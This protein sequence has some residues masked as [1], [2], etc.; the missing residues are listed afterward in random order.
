MCRWNP[1][2]A[3]CPP[4][5]FVRQCNVTRLMTSRVSRQVSQDPGDF[6][7]PDKNSDEPA[8]RTLAPPAACVARLTCAASSRVGAKTSPHG[9][10][11]G[12]RDPDLGRRPVPGRRS[13]AA[14]G[15]TEPRGEARPPPPPPRCGQQ[16]RQTSRHMPLAFAKPRGNGSGHPSLERCSVTASK[17]RKPGN[18]IVWL[19]HRVGL[20][21][22]S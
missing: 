7:N 6:G 2:L 1:T 3:Q 18:C 10:G 14:R 20:L 19:E 8:R 13:H 9:I 22:M 4:G 5:E 12:R 15:R 17:L 21:E 16:E 11:L